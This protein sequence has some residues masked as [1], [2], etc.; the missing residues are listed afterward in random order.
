MRGVRAALRC[1]AKLAEMRPGIKARIGKD[2]FMRDRHQ[3]GAARWWGTWARNDTFR[4]H[5]ARRRR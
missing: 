2:M 4:L 5:D 1:Q 3:H